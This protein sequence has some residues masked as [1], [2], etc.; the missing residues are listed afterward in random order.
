[1]Q[2]AEE[3]IT[4]CNDGQFSV[5]LV[6][7][8]LFQDSILTPKNSAFSFYLL[9]MVLFWHYESQNDLSNKRFSN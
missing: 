4:H 7:D 1:M 5:L 3:R 2:G 6:F 8:S 9:S